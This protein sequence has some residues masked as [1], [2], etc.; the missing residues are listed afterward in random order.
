M[1]A[2]RRGWAIVAALSV[3]ET[4]SWGVLYYGFTAFLRPI[5][6]DTGWSRGTLSTAFSLALLVQG[7]AALWVGRWLDRHSPRLLM[8]LGSCAATLAVLAWSQ[9]RHP[10]AFTALWAVIGLVMATV[11]YEP[12]F[13]VVTKWFREGR[14]RALTT[15]TLVA[16]LASTIFLPLENHLIETYGWRR[17][18]VILAVLLGGITIPLHALVLRK[19]PVAVGPPASGPAPTGPGPSSSGDHT[20]GQALRS[21]PFWFLAAAFVSSS[22]VISALAVHQVALLVDAGHAPAFAAGVTG[23]L[24]AMQLPGRL[25]FAPLEG[26]AGRRGATVVVFAALTVG[27]AVLVRS[28]SATAVWVFVVLYGMGRGMAT[29]LRA[30]LVADLFGATNYGG[31]SG[32]LS[33]C[34]TV[35]TAAGP[36]AAGLLFDATGGYRILLR[37][38]LALALAATVL[39]A[40][41]ERGGYRQPA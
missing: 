5:S 2:G 15:V 17:A 6:E 39:S 33:S 28:S 29:L 8:T 22:F 19:A 18:L 10:W 25:L 23:A 16:G 13:T 41:V 3:T 12:A 27:V 9:V 4:V 21:A 14:R 36:L 34:T 30:T 1:G 11:L 31:I 32:V 7:G 35:A 26:V 38:L 24:G 37:V 20:V 40:M